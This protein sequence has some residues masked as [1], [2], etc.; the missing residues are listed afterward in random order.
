MNAVFIFYDC[1]KKDR[2]K[3]FKEAIDDIYGLVD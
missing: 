2:R 1:S 3:K